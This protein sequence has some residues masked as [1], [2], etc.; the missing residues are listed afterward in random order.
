MSFPAVGTYRREMQISPSFSGC[1]EE[2]GGEIKALPVQ[3]KG[4]QGLDTITHPGPPKPFSVQAQAG[5]LC[6]NTRI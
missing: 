3:D 2:Q 6:T 5:T 1:Q 4:L